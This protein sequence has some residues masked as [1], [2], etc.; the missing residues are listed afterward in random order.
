M[1]SNIVPERAQKDANRF[2]HSCCHTRDILRFL[3][4]YSQDMLHFWYL[5]AV[6]C[7]ISWRIIPRT[8]W[9]VSLVSKSPKWIVPSI[10][11]M[12]ENHGYSIN[13]LLNGW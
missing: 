7:M 2:L 13:H 6:A 8:N 5:L 4:W 9:L 11:A 1:G 12:G 10:S 3:F